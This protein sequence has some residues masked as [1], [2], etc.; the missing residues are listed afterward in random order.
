MAGPRESERDIVAEVRRGV[1]APVYYVF[2][3]ERFLVARTVTAIREAVL[4]ERTRAFNL[5][6]IDCKEASR[7]G[8]RI[9]AAARTLPM[10]AHRRLVL[11]KDAD[12]L[13]AADFEA[14]TEYLAEP[15]P[16]S[17]VVLVAETADQ[18]RKFFTQLKKVGV[19]AKYEPLYERQLRPFVDGEAR[20]AGVTLEPGAA[21]L[22][23]QV[24]GADLAQLASALEQLSLYASPRTRI[25]V[26]D[27]EEIVAET[28][29]HSVFDLAN[30]VGDGDARRA[31]HQLGRMLAAKEPAVKILFMLTRHFRQLFTARDLDGRGAGRDELAQA[32][33]IPPFFV[34]GLVKQ[35]RKLKPGRFQRSFEVLYQAD[36]ALKGSKLGDE[37]VLERVILELCGLGAAA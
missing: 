6:V 33:G 22:L 37:L 19:V 13:D 34:E 28:R 25:T 21:E 11:A 2:G 3:K 5:D 23:V 9:A 15:S 30:A 24:I 29:Q 10:L 8:E 20:R 16:T 1:I 4:E 7:P 31:L 35:A 17:C 36:R 18:R 32:L 27:V 12:E 14:L 26:A